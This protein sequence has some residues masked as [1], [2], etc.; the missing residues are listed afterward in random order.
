[1]GWIELPVDEMAARY[2]A[3]ESTHA[4]ARAY[5]VCQQTTRCRLLAA[6]VTMRPRGVPPGRKRRHKRGGPLH[7]NFGYLQTH[8]RDGNHCRVHRGCWEAYHGAIPDGHVIHHRDEDRMNNTVG[9]LSCMTNSEHSSWHR[10]R[11]SMTRN[12]RDCI[13]LGTGLC[14]R[15]EVWARHHKPCH[16]CEHYITREGDQDEPANET[17]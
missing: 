1:M 12:K 5:G 17:A 3:G 8:D 10:R 16:D 15:N 2:E 6:G 14:P 11:P 13:R 9:N 4:L 7:T